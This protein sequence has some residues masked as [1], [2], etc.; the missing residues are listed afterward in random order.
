MGRSDLAVIQFREKVDM[1]VPIIVISVSIT[2]AIVCYIV[3]F[4]AHEFF[5]RE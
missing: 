5:V 4:K 1:V 3:I 2:T